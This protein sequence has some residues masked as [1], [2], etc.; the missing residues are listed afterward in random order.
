MA[1]T[2]SLFLLN[3]VFHKTS[4]ISIKLGGCVAAWHNGYLVG[5]WEYFIACLIVASGHFALCLCVAEVTSITSF[6]GITILTGVGV[7]SV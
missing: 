5:V 3:S 7:L 6:P 2:P 1:I 4:G